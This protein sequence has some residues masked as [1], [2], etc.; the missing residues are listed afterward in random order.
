MN[1]NLQ[2]FENIKPINQNRSKSSKDYK[3]QL[4]DFILDFSFDSFYE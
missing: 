1:F 2:V 4:S 3:E